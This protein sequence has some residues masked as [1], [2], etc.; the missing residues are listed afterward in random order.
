ML[1]RFFSAILVGILGFGMAGAGF[2]ATADARPSQRSKPVSGL[3]EEWSFAQ[4]LEKDKDYDFTARS[5][6]LASAA[7]RSGSLSHARRAAALYTLGETRTSSARSLVEPWLHSGTVEERCAAIAAWGELAVQPEGEDPVLVQ[8]LTDADL[9]VAES[10]LL[11]MYMSTPKLAMERVAFLVANPE[12]PLA[13]AAGHILQL[14]ERGLCSAPGPVTRRLELR[15]Q[16]ARM[17][18]TVKGQTW[19]ASL[20]EELSKD[21]FF[22]DRSLLIE[23]GTLDDP[24]VP[25]HLLEW[26]LLNPGEEAPA[27]TMML[28]MPSAMD[29]LVKQGMW[30]PLNDAQNQAILDVAE[31]RGCSRLI[32]ETLGQLA[33]QPQYR[34][35]IAGWLVGV[36]PAYRDAI[37]EHL[38]SPVPSVRAQAA[39]SAGQARRAELVS[40]L[41]DL[42]RDPEISVRIEALVARVR[43]GDRALA[44]EPL[45]DIFIEQRGQF[46]DADRDLALRSM[47]AAHNDRV[48]DLVHN[49]RVALGSGPERAK[50][51]AILLLGGRKLDS[52]GIREIFSTTVGH[53]FWSLKMV[54][55]LG[56]S[57]L[58]EDRRL[59]ENAFPDPTS[60]AL[61]LILSN[62][63]LAHLSEEVVPLLKH[64]VWNGDFN[65]SCLAAIL[66]ADRYG[67]SRLMQWLEHPPIGAHVEDLRRLGFMV[68]SLGGK[69]AIDLLTKNL[70]AT[71]GADRPELQGALLGALSARTY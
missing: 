53:D 43:E 64:A 16:A 69:E 61:N 20:I 40:R 49:I 68:G 45:R 63:L 33:L 57:G 36:D 62:A 32:P 7:L 59:L 70:G 47:L 19:T 2:L 22:I 5:G 15:W 38:L 42:S 25:D 29:E 54:E 24:R 23:A 6:Q 71:A 51:T 3:P 27:L 13:P 67:P 10:A 12:Q 18:G 14:F 26:L 11:A 46:S 48:L 4:L 50:F 34:Q 58:P 9:P 17:F 44:W 56:H 66:V 28:K 55:A 30:V 41:R 31:S 37:E 60:Y 65:Q 52:S 39:R 8:A 21:L 35:R 1:H